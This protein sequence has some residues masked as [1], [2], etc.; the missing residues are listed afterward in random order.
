MCS[1]N[2]GAQ[3]NSPKRCRPRVLLR[4]FWT[5]TE[6]LGHAMAICSENKTLLHNT[7][8]FYTGSIDKIMHLTRKTRLT[9]INL[10]RLQFQV[11]SRINWVQYIPDTYSELV[12]RNFSTIMDWSLC[13]INVWRRLW[14]HRGRLELRAVKFED[15]WRIDLELQVRTTERAHKVLNISC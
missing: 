10:Q 12:M 8:Y 3:T 11:A 4:S 1:Q 7:Y 9:I 6:R 2:G 13:R 5:L 14:L 15:C